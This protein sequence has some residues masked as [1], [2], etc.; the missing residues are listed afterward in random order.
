MSNITSLQ[1]YEI[2]IKFVLRKPNRYTKKNLD[3]A[4][5][6][7]RKLCEDGYTIRNANEAYQRACDEVNKKGEVSK[8]GFYLVRLKG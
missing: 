2:F 3:K 1:K 8:N 4:D 5:L 6:L 7:R